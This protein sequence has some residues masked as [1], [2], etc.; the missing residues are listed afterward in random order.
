M[1]PSPS[2]LVTLPPGH[3]LISIAE[4]TGSGVPVVF[5]N[6]LAADMSMWSDVH[7]K[8]APRPSLRFDARGHGGSDIVPGDCLVADLARDVLVL[9]DAN[10]IDRA[11]LCGLSLGGVIAMWLAE[12]EPSRVAGLVLANTAVSFPP[13]QMW[14]DRAISARFEG[15]DSIVAPT[16]QR[17]LTDDFRMKYPDTEAAVKEMIAVTPG[18]GY[19]ACCAALASAEYSEA[20][21]S[22]VGPVL[23]LAGEHDQ[24]TPVARAEEMKALCYSAELVVLDAA[25]LSSIE[26]PDAF[27]SHL[28][29]FL[30]Q[31]DQQVIANE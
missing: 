23:L 7:A 26:A 5:L 19:A 14:R 31:V 3:R 18:E 10:G 24:S 11:V 12:N 28:D 21:S 22:Y 9:M 4:S 15:M 16:L 30:A 29:R 27:A 2:S 25:H 17:W 20:L 13:A 6:S 1:T 8:L